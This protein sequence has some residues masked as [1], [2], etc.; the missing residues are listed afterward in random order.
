MGAKVIEKHFTLDKTLKG[1]DHYHAMDPSDIV[2][3]K[4]DVYKRQILMWIN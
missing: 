3:I 1:N 4:Q 2:E